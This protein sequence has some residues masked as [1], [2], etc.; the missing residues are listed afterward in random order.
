MSQNL[1]GTINTLTVNLANFVGHL[2]AQLERHKAER[3]W[4]QDAF[5]QTLETLCSE[6]DIPYE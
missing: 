4:R 6:F 3:E 2:D 1:V 5:S